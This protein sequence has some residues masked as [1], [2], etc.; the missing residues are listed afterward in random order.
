M[1]TRACRSIRLM[2]G[3][4]LFLTAA[5]LL[6]VAPPAWAKVKLPK[7]GRLNFP[8]SGQTT[9]FTADK[10]DGI[11]GAVAVPDDGT[12][13]TGATLSYQDNGDGTI[14]DL[15]TGLQWEKKN[16]LDTTPNFSNL[17]DADNTYL[18]SGN[19]SQE[20]IWDWLDDVNAEGG[21]GF[22]GH[23]DWRI[24]NVKELQS[25]V[26]Y[27][28]FW[29]SIDPA[30]GDTAASIYWSSSTL[31]VVPALAWLVNFSFGLVDFSIGDGK[32]NSIFVR[33]VRG[34]CL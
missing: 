12:V 29:P 11:G 16:S 19:G 21:T 32:S 17:H 2:G 18:W 25:I 8:A 26:D 23:T 31:A 14:T 20:T 6:A 9:A 7:C 24:P 10:N 28:V 5:L 4:T 13:Q 34:G 1:R 15:N 3:A 30:F 27:G 33:A 22:A